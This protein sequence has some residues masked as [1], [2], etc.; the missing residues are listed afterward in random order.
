V[1]WAVLV[2]VFLMAFTNGAND[3]F[4]PV[5]TIY[6]SGTATYRTALAWATI[7]QIAGSM[8]AMVLAA[9]LVFAFTGKGLVPADLAAAPEFFAA[10]ATGTMGTVLIATIVGMPISTTHALTG[11]L[12]GAAVVAGRGINLDAL[13]RS[14]FLP[15]AVSPVLAIGA[16]II[17]F[18]IAKWS[19][20]ALGIERESC[21]CV[22]TQAVPDT[23]NLRAAAAVVA[24]VVTVGTTEQC[25]EQ[26]DRQRGVV[27]SAQLALDVFHFL[28]AGAIAFA[29]GLN[30][31][32]KILAIALAAHATGVTVGVPLIGLAM[33]LG[34]VLNARKVAETMSHKITPLTAGQGVIA[35][36]TSA[37]LIIG[38]SRAGLPVSTTH[39]SSSAIFGI[40]V[41]N[42]SARWKVIASILAA[43]VSTLPVGAVLGGLAYLALA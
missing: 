43:W 21:V 33:A 23:A 39:V 37:V 22:G 29:R 35:N 17:I 30:D 28:S 15:L 31:T 24:P 19:R 34:G 9:D 16:T 6:G 18:A 7:A 14:F 41:V 38:A 10:V 12:V 13:G 40:G 8:L 27:I 42:R 3:N 1:T 36:V 25:A 4:K 26:F 2:A 5:A 32:P 20:R 11:A